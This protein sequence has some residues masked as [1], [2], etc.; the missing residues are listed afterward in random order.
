[1]LYNNNFIVYLQEDQ[2]LQEDREVRGDL[3][4]PERKKERHKNWYYN[5]TWRKHQTENTFAGIAVMKLR[6]ECY[7]LSSIQSS[8]SVIIH[9]L[10]KHL[11]LCF[12][13]KRNLQLGHQCQEDQAH[14]DLL[15]YPIQHNKQTTYMNY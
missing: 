3:Y 6:Y 12:V 1:M 5:E 10:R 13:Q 7:V 2:E 14:Q 9:E 4:H 8:G 15:G 11:H